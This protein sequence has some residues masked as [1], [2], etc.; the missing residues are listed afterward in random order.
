MR[1]IDS[2]HFDQPIFVMKQ[3]CVRVDNLITMENGV[4]VTSFPSVKRYESSPPNDHQSFITVMPEIVEEAVPPPKPKEKLVLVRPLKNYD[5]PN[6]YKRFFNYGFEDGANITQSMMQE[7]LDVLEILVSGLR[8]ENYS[9]YLSMLLYLEEHQTL[10]DLKMYCMKNAPLR[11]A[12]SSQSQVTLDVGWNANCSV[13]TVTVAIGNFQVPGLA[14]NRPSVLKGDGIYFSVREGEHY[15]TYKGWVNKVCNTSLTVG[16]GKMFMRKFIDNLKVTVHFSFN[17]MCLKMEHRALELMT[18][19][20]PT[21]CFPQTFGGYAKQKPIMSWYNK[22]VMSNHQQAQAVQNIVNGSSLPSPYLLFGPPGTGKTVT[23]IYFGASTT[24]ILATAPSN[25]ASDLLA[26]R[27]LQSIPPSKLIR[28]YSPSRDWA[29]VPEVLKSTANFCDRECYFPSLT[30]LKSYR[31]IVATL[32]CAGRLVSGGFPAGHFTHIFVDECGHGMEPTSLVPVAGLL[33]DQRRPGQLVLSGDPKQLGPIIRSPVAKRLGLAE[34][35]LERLM[36]SNQLYQKQSDGSYIPQVLTKLVKNFRSHPHILKVPNE[37]FYDGDLE[38]C[39]D[40]GVTHLACNWEELP[41]KDVPLIFH[42]VVG[43]DEQDQDSPSFFNVAEVDLVVKYVKKI[44]DSKFCGRQ[45]KAADIGII[46][47]YRRQIDKLHRALERSRLRGL[48]VGSVEEFQGQERTV[49]I[50]STV[51]SNPAKLALDRKFRLG[52]LREPKRFNVAMTRAK[53]LLIVIG[54]PHIL[55]Q[56]PNWRSLLE[57]AIKLG[58]F[59]GCPNFKLNP[60]SLHAQDL[61]E[62][63]VPV[64]EKLEKQRALTKELLD[65]DEEHWN[66]SLMHQHKLNT[67]VNNLMDKIKAINFFSEIPEVSELEKE[68]SPPFN[69]SEQ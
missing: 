53:S 43:K 1:Q 11:K 49:I 46:S 30:E 28:L 47:P 56:D 51:R 3:I 15:R 29:N 68:V 65:K 48:S 59:T 8:E 2:V 20:V 25:S 58:G 4:E 18:E 61:N 19:Q 16:M 36:T 37:L 62:L 5:L 60:Q 10:C 34:S 63:R 66:Q 32:I 23:V 69:T 50:V 13:S 44:L 33:G 42:G 39:G 21:V 14:E 45:M 6:N 12:K 17:R 40:V 9:Q 27:L 26:E 57:W 67:D 35:L 52:F 22:L 41:K 64:R 38:P 24:Y 7:K 55:Q 54:N 31:I